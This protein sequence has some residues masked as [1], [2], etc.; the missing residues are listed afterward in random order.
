[1]VALA[2]IA[3]ALSM[4]ACWRK[5]AGSLDADAWILSCALTMVLLGIGATLLAVFGLLRPMPLSA[6]LIGGALALRPWRWEAPVGANAAAR[7]RSR[8]LTIALLAVLGVGVTLRLPPIEYAL[9][10]RDQGTYTL[11]AEQMMRTGSV[12]LR[13]DVLPRAHA[14]ARDAPR[15]GP[16]DILG[17]VPTSG[18]PW[19][20]DV[21]EGAYRPGL[22]LADRATGRVT[23]QFMHALPAVLAS[24][25]LAFGAAGP[26]IAVALI[27][28]LGLGIFVLVV[29]RLWPRGPWAVLAAG[30]VCLSPLSIWVHRNALTEGLASVALWGAALCVLRVRDG[31]AGGLPAAGLLLG[32]TAWLRG[33]GLLVAPLVGLMLWGLPRREGREVAVRIY[34]AVVLASVLVHTATSYPYLHDELSRMAKDLHP[35]PAQLAVAALAVVLLLGAGDRL[36][37]RLGRTESPDGTRWLGWVGLSFVLALVLHTLLAAGAPPRPFSRLDPA[38]VLLGW[39]QLA[40]AIFGAVALWRLR[41]PAAS[42]ATAWLGAIGAALVLPLLLYARRNLP[43]AG[44]YY[45]GRYLAVELLPLCAVLATA[46]LVRAHG[47]LLSWRGAALAHAPAVIAGGLVLLSVTRPLADHPVTRLQEFAGARD[48][49]DAIADAV[50]PGA[51]V[52]AGGEGWHHGHTF[53]QVGGALVLSHGIA[54]L[55]YRSREAAYAT[56]FELLVAG[57]QASGE[58]PPPVYLL[59]NEATKHARLPRD[60]GS[61]KP[62][63]I[64]ALDDLLEPPFVATHVELL[65][66]F[67][68]RLTPVRDA[69]PQQ[70]TRDGLR[71]ALLRVRVSP[72]AA[73]RHERLYP[74]GG[75]E[76]VALQPAASR[77]ITCLSPGQP[78]TL[79]PPLRGGAGPGPV[80][81]V[82]VLVPGT[83][84]HAQTL[85]VAID[86]ESVT[87]PAPGARRRPRDTL[88]PLWVASRPRA[89]EVGALP[90]RSA[91]ATC[92]HG[93]IA[94]VRLIGP[95]SSALGHASAVARTWPPPRELGHPVDA[96]R[97]VSGRG[98]SKLR[99]GLELDGA[100][101]R[102]NAIEL[103]A[104]GAM[105]WAPEPL[106]DEGRAPFDLVVTLTA[107]SPAAGTRLDVLVDG[108]R[109]TSIAPPANHPRS[110]QSKPVVVTP[111]GPVGRIGLALHAD[112]PDAWIRVRDVGLFSHGGA[113]RG[114]LV[115]R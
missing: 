108:Q 96:L 10:G 84:A 20:A 14:D 85:K 21:Y 51:V 89:I 99:A 54:V 3:F 33:H 46:G 42:P 26:A 106:P 78:T 48:V 30:L 67:V 61:S 81:V 69:I 16:A 24:F 27:G 80:G 70:V 35:T 23:P 101:V 68:Q 29:R 91:T 25:G 76:R 63:R 37:P 11:R 72:Q 105:Q 113:V 83:A 7:P 104:G 18:E 9:A 41:L 86:G 66:M 43:Q 115:A 71:M 15:P 90:R 31:E 110:W 102:G 47:L 82:L 50:E 64:G 38:T 60:G 32:A 4:F 52:I 12:A 92:P 6:V 74:A 77:G 112:D 1:M 49:V 36:R 19:R 114:S 87:V 97:W 22:Y 39:P 17:L 100:R 58:P 56:M 40:L 98:L 53:N 75:V 94:E 13:D 5:V 59:V 88:G 111:P 28:A 2:L 45:Y 34:G 44:L 93:G 65:E 8:A 103:S 57:P 55:P 73:R 109:V 95:P 62:P 79:V 107:T